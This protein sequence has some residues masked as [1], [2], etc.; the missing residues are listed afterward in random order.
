[1]KSYQLGRRAARRRCFRCSAEWWWR[2]GACPSSA[3]TGH[4]QYKHQYIAALQLLS[5]RC[6]KSI[7]QILKVS[8]RNPSWI[9]WKNPFKGFH[10]FNPVIQIRD[11]LERISMRILILGSIGTFTNGSGCGSV[12]KSSVNFTLQKYFLFIFLDV[13]IMKFK[14]VKICLMIKIKSL[15]RKFVY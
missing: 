3:S 11:I 4:L 9:V 15:A 1:M 12:P 8:R 14:I 2:G 6:R 13:L 5:Q 7:W 10:L